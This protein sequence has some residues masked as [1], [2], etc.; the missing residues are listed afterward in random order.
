MTDT[1][2][3]ATDT[4][5]E[6]GLLVFTP[7][8]LG[9][10]DARGSGWYGMVLLAVSEGSLFAFVL[11]SYCYMAFHYGRA[12]LPEKLPSFT[13]SGPNTG[14]ILVGAAAV[15]LADRAIRRNARW[16]SAAGMAVAFVLGCLFLWFQWMEWSGKPF[17]LQMNSYASVY[18]LVT[19]IHVAHVVAGV[20]MLAAMTIWTAAGMFDMRRRDFV[21]NTMFYWMFV[22]LLWVAVLLTIYV[23]PYMFYR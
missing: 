22:A 13:Y 14:F 19:G 23:S 1:Q 21:T 4:R 10:M 18:F 2:V 11:F 16:L 6:D 5:D 3:H 8:D 20:V 12:W 7:R 17:G 9:A 15:F